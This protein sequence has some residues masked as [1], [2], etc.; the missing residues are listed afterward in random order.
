MFWSVCAKTLNIFLVMF[1]LLLHNKNTKRVMIST[2]ITNNEVFLK[3]NYELIFRYNSQSFPR[4]LSFFELKLKFNLNTKMSDD[5]SEPKVRWLYSWLTIDVK[6]VLFCELFLLFR[7]WIGDRDPSLSSG[8][9]EIL[10]QVTYRLCLCWEPALKTWVFCWFTY[11]LKL[12][13]RFKLNS[14]QSKLQIT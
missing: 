8:K 10:F 13:S 9:L 12:L 4:V 5:W 14:F 1:W 11:S 6:I 3:K 7:L 2:I